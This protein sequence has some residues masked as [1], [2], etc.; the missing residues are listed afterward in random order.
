MKKKLFLLLL[1]PVLGFSQAVE[2]TSGSETAATQPFDN[3][4]RLFKDWSV[5]LGGGGA[6]MTHAD[7][8]SFYDGD[9]NWGW[10]GYVSLDKQISQ[11]FGISLMYTRGETKQKAYLN[12]AAGV[13]H[14][15]T[16]FD[17]IALLGDINFSAL[18]RKANSKSSFKWALHG[19]AGIGVMGYK[20]F[21]QDDNVLSQ[22][23][24]KIKQDIDVGSFSYIGGVGLKYNLSRLLDLE[25][26]TLYLLSG[27]EEFDGGGWT[28]EA[29]PGYN[30]INDTYSDNAWLVNLGISFK[31]GKHPVHLR[32]AD[33]LQKAY[34]DAATLEE[35]IGNFQVCEKGDLDND[36]ICDDWD[37]QLDTPAG[38]RVDGSG[39][40]LDIDLD[41]V[42]DLNDKCVTI[43]GP[44]ENNGCPNI[45]PNTITPEKQE[46]IDDINKYFNGIEFELGKAIIRPQSY[47]DLDKTAD[48][49]K[50]F[51]AGESF[52]VVGA[53]DSRGS[54]ELNKKLSLARANAVL[55]YLVSKGVSPSILS[56]E[57]RGKDDLKYTECDPA[58]NCPEWKNEANRRVYFISK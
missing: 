10:N 7:L 27:D 32:W 58:S 42:I 13:G 50:R 37:R 11:V 24:M 33:P 21:L 28:R 55:E 34:A 47:R 1:L 45:N 5:S 49:I 56:A 54:A 8:T 9:I 12:E 40:A 44:I 30:L 3:K 53:A 29:I 31:L 15:S 52:I 26:R 16:K 18:L 22:W 38:A 43:P 6:F 36:A 35:K 48:I 51:G 39:V 17:Q 4:S 41:G 23:P 20:T 19:Y 46:A 57:G 2:Q 25:L 14:G